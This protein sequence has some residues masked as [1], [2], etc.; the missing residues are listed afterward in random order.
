MVTVQFLHYLPVK[1]G[2]MLH[3]HTQQHSC[4]MVLL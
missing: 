4:T 3:V 1:S 2:C